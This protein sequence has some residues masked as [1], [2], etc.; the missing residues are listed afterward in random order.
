MKRTF[1]E[2]DI[3]FGVRYEIRS[4]LYEYAKQKGVPIY[5][6]GN[7]NKDDCDYYPNITFNMGELCGNKSSNNGRE[8]T[9]S[10]FFEY[11]DNWAELNNPAVQVVLNNEY[12]AIVTCDKVKVGCQEF[13]HEKIEELYKAVQSFK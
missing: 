4:T 1:K 9:L 13:T 8:I 2:G 5:N 11:C 6:K 12:S 3:L 10:Q 7:V